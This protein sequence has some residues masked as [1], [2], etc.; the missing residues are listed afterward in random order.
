MPPFRIHQTRNKPERILLRLIKG[1][2]IIPQILPNVVET[3]ETVP[4]KK[5]KRISV[6]QLKEII[7][8]LNADLSGLSPELKDLLDLDEF[9]ADQVEEKETKEETK[10]ET[11]EEESDLEDDDV[12]IIDI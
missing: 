8:L 4:E 9:E 12:L 10:D 11:K 5:K 2:Y 3:Q 1:M 6:S 7:K